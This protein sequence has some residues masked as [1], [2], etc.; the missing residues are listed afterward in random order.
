MRI[1]PEDSCGIVIDY[2]EKLLPAIAENK[3]LLFRTTELLEGLSVLGV[4]LLVT[5]QYE[6]GL[7][8]TVP[9]IEKAAGRAEHFDKISFS[10]YG[11][12]AV[13]TALSGLAAQP[14]RPRKNVI[15]CGI[16]ADICV[17]QTVLDLCEASCCPVLVEDCISSRQLHDKKIAVMRA[18]QEGAV[19]TTCESLLFEL[20]GRAGTP[21]TPQFKQISALIKAKEKS[22]LC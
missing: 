20:A 19:V 7:G 5:T 4:P 14:D 21:G 13:R 16:E 17:L 6:K 12:E 10:A 9:E 8:A 15:I 18:Y 11:D 22:R 2:Q 1:L 3:E